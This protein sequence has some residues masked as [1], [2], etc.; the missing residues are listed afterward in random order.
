MTVKRAA[1]H[2]NVMTSLHPKPKPGRAKKA[3]SHMRGV[4]LQ[5]GFIWDTTPE[6]FPY[7]P[8]E[9]GDIRFRSKP[10]KTKTQIYKMA[11]D[12]ICRNLV[13]WRD[14]VTCVLAEVD[15]SKCSNVPNWGHVIPQGGSTFLVY[16]PSNWFR[17]CSAHNKIHDKVNPLIYTEWYRHKWGNTALEMLK[18]AQIDNRAVDWNDRDYFDWLIELSELYDMRHAFGSATIEQKVTAGFY[19]TIIREAW[20]KDGRT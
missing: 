16:E 13:E 14:G 5:C 3:K 10:Y 12:Q 18:Q 7:C 4:C 8:K 11:L 20:I 15:G 19:G 2:H 17:Q 9:L 6:H 1:D